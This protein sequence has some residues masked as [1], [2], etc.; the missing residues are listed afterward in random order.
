V[1]DLLR[2]I[3]EDPR[4]AATNATFSSLFSKE[5][6]FSYVGMGALNSSWVEEES[7]ASA[8]A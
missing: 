4:D 2:R 7:L 1:Y 5:K 3:G 8:A 6:V